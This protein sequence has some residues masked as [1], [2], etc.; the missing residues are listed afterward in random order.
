MTNSEAVRQ[1]LSILDAKRAQGPVVVVPSA[2]GGITDLLDGIAA[3]ASAGDESYRADFSTIEARHLKMIREV[4]PLQAQTSVISWFKQQ[5]NQLE[6]VCRGVYLVRELTP[7]VQAWVLSYGERFS[8]RILH[9]ALPADWGNCRYW[10]ALELVVTDNQYLKATV[11]MPE[12]KARLMKATREGLDVAVMPGFVAANPK[13][14]VTTLGRGG[15]DYTAAIVAA[16]LWADALE[17][18]TDVD[19]MLTADPRYVADARP[20]KEVTYEEALELAHFGAKVLYPPTLQPILQEQVPLYVKNTFNPEAPGTKIHQKAERLHE[21]TGLSAIPEIALLTVVGAGMVAVPGYASRLFGALHEAAINVILITQ[22]SSEHAIGVAVAALDVAAAE[23]AL[24]HTFEEE[25]AKGWV[26]QIKVE[27]EVSILAVV[28][29]NMKQRAGLA[30]HTFSALGRNGINVKAIA[31][32]SSERNIS[33]VI[34]KPNLVKALNVLHEEFFLSATKKIHLFMVGTG[35]VGK[36]LLRQITLQRKYLREEQGTELVLCG[37]ANSRK[38]ILNDQGI[39]AEKAIDLLEKD[40]EPAQMGKFLQKMAEMNLRHS[41]WIDNTAS[42][43][44][45]SIYEQVMASKVSI[46]ASNKLACSGA[47]DRYQQLKQAAID[48]RVSFLFET[49]VGAGLPVIDQLAGLRHSG[50]RITRIEAVLSGSLNYIFSTYDTTKSFAEVVAEAKEKG[51]T[52]PDPRADL[53]GA[54]VGRKIL[55]LARES[56]YAIAPEEVDL[57]SFLP[58]SI[59]NEGDITAFFD[60]LATSEAYFA[61]KFNAAYKE[62]RRLRMLASLVDGMAKV[63]LEEV[64]LDHPSYN[65]SGTDNLIMFYTERYGSLPLVVRGAGAGAG[66]TA[67]GVFAD[68]L[69]TQHYWD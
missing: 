65:L 2:L 69:R 67:A 13:S 53:S 44:V 4:V 57:Q 25:L 32:G 59:P 20:L 41:V 1:V 37:V 9:A 12:T 54:D 6:D 27:E 52:E 23:K 55:I 15:S 61:G 31:Q 29:E 11:D 50:D 21:I 17:I 40:G 64:S 62:S 7:K 34:R 3:K 46:V 28:G 19:G 63:S 30:G 39:E 8:S 24:A 45:V 49:N 35:L 33:L 22:A 47:L 18:W 10:N 5:L 14:E 51:F 66:V 43:E 26:E 38:M 60:A 58:D 48:N 16:A 56:G 42:Q 68:I 36:E